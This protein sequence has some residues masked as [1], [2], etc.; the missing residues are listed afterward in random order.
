[1]LRQAECG[2]VLPVPMQR[3]GFLRIAHD[4]IQDA[5]CEWHPF[6]MLSGTE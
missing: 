1:M 4:L 3:H 6:R 5:V 2:Q